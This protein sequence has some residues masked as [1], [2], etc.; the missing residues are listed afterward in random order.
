MAGDARR[1]RPEDRPPAAGLHRPGAARL[2]AAGEEEIAPFLVRLAIVLFIGGVLHAAPQRRVAFT[3][4]DLPGRIADSCNVAELERLNR[5]LVGAIVRN[6]MPAT[7]LVVESAVCARQRHRIGRLYEIWLAAG[8]ELGNHTHSHR[9][10]NRVPLEEYQEDVI[11]GERTLAPLLAR[12]GERL[13]Y[14]RYPFLRSGTELRK[15]RA[16]EDFLRRRGYVNAPVT[17]DN[18]EYIY[19]AA[20]A[21][22]LR[23]RDAGLAKHIAGDYIRYMDSIFAFYEKL[24]RDTLGYELPQILL[25]HVNQLNAD[26]LD[27]LTEMTRR[28]GYELISMERALRDKAYGRVDSYIGSRGLSWLQRWALDDGKKPPVHPEVPEWVMELYRTR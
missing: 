8:L 13:R 12:R 20:Y 1:S 5:T 24:S 4:D 3:F 18:D 2:R 27:R 11:A 6:E 15:K 9:D 28:R 25:L 17:I 7:G 19:A 14:F 10:F 22:A 23:R 16:F 26:H 21:G